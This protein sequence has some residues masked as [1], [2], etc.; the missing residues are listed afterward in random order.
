MAQTIDQ[1]YILLQTTLHALH[2]FIHTRTQDPKSRKLWSKANKL[3]LP[4]STL[5]GIACEDLASIGSVGR[6]EGFA[7][8]LSTGE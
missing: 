8:F 1:H 4:S 3:G 5:V 2:T 6:C 7:F